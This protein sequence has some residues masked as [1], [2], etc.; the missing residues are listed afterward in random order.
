MFIDLGSKFLS[1]ETTT[2][3]FARALGTCL[4]PGD[5]VLLKGDI[6][7]GKSTFSRAIIQSLQDE[8][9]DV[10]SPTFTL[11]QTYETNAGEV[12]HSDLYRLGS[13]YEVDELGLWDAFESA[14]CLVEWPEILLEVAPKHSLLL[15]FKVVQ[16][17][18]A[19]Q[20]TLSSKARTWAE[21]LKG[22][23]LA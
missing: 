1:Q 23:G 13:I 5:I 16:D 17:G 15:E 10:P 19:R 11:V 18:A 20:L 8:P 7:A 3:H 14:I 2:Q 12:W 21:R 22:I 4:A 9:E 6:G